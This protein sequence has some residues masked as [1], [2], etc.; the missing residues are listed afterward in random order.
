M[1]LLM[2]RIN[3]FNKCL[4][5]WR[6]KKNQFVTHRLL[7]VDTYSIPQ[8][9]QYYPILLTALQNW[10]SLAQVTFWASVLE[11]YRIPLTPKI[12]FYVFSTT[13]NISLME[14]T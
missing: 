4:Q 6:K 8:N 1:G 9:K 7:L 5:D 3:Y 2:L 12:N 11:L 14:M 13:P 10:V